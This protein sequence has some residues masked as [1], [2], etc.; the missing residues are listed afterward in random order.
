MVE[1]AHGV[2]LSIG[3]HKLSAPCHARSERRVPAYGNGSIAP[4]PHCPAPQAISGCEFNTLNE[5]LTARP[6]S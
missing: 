6:H 4:R 5:R 1:A 3:R 2:K